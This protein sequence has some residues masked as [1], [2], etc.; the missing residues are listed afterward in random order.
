MS[1]NT[2]PQTC[3]RRRLEG[4]GQSHHLRNQHL[5]Y[6]CWST[7]TVISSSLSITAASCTTP[8]SGKS[9]FSDNLERRSGSQIYPKTTVNSGV[10]RWFTENSAATLDGWS[11][12]TKKRGPAAAHAGTHDV[13][14]ENGC[15]GARAKYG[16]TEKCTDSLLDLKAKMPSQRIKTLHVIS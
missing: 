4:S 5:Y 9:S 8:V 11:I 10:C 2:L 14:T 7:C 1:S 3:G 15:P 13:C 16:T 6:R 12:R